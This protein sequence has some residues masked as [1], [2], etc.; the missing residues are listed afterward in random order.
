MS[1]S[2]QE[3]TRIS[4]PAQVMAC[5][6]QCPILTDR[7][8]GADC[9]SNGARLC[10]RDPPQ[11]VRQQTIHMKPL[12]LR[13]SNVLRL[14]LRTQPRSIKSGHYPGRAQTNCQPPIGTPLVRIPGKRCCPS[15]ESSLNVGQSWI[16]KIFTKAN[17][18]RS[19]RR[20]IHAATTPPC[21]PAGISSQYES[22]VKAR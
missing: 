15:R 10:R 13:P 12:H 4:S 2:S 21:N 22:A 19:G 17:T 9:L 8:A 6:W 20:N 18:L 1:C 3:D 5:F 11:Q 16:P 7:D 14:V